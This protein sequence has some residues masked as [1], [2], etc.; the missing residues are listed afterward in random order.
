LSYF[1]TVVLVH[2]LFT[3]LRLGALTLP[4]RIIMAPLTRCRATPGTFA[5]NALMADHYAARAS[6][7]LL[8]AEATVISEEARGFPNT[9]GCYNAAQAAG[10]RLV[11]DAVHA[12][13][14]RIFLQLWHQGRTASRA[15]N[16][17]VEPVGPSAVAGWKTGFGGVG[18]APREA[19]EADI[20]RI[21]GD[22]R[23]AA[24]TARD[25]GFD[26]VE[27]HAANGYLPN[28]FL[29]T[30][31]NKRTDAWGGTVEKRARFLSEALDALL[32][33]W[34]ADRVGVRVSPAGHWQDMHD[35]EPLALW[36]HVGALLQAK[37]GLAYVHVVEPRDTGLGAA[38]TD[39]V[40]LQ[41]TAA[42]FRPL[43]SGP[44]LSAGGHDLSSATEYVGAGR[45]DAAVFGRWFISNPDLVKRFQMAAAEGRAPVLNP[46]NRDTFYASGVRPPHVIPL[47]ATPPLSHIPLPHT[48]TTTTTTTTR[49]RA[50]T[51]IQA[52]G[53]ND[54]TPLD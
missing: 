29:C 22:Y 28:Q 35:A 10:W 21:L 45:A 53:Y 33:E 1:F 5:A 31:S 20:A 25:A 26:G 18:E 2:M 14:G 37:G 42:F 12:A 40:D 4:N 32:Q 52:E 13:G 9:P 38:P 19:T 41:L 54:Y 7:G 30:S 16:G 34:P 3:P 51:Q 23:A 39:P 50:H 8:I 17:G 47:C 6:A 27:L 44:I 43:F 24:R 49:A 36:A 46:Y 48:T 11:T 15:L